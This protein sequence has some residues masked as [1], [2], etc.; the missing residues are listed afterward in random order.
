MNCLRSFCFMYYFGGIIN[1]KKNIHYLG[2]RYSCSGVQA[3]WLVSTVTKNVV[4][5]WQ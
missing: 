3:R 5:G 2:G 4:K 1:I